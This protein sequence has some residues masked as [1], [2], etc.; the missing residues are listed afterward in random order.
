M[1]Y[2]FLRML[3]FE[4]VDVIY[5]VAHILGLHNLNVERMLF[6]IKCKISLLTWGGYRDGNKDIK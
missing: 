4:N 6:I 2:T 5:P 1:L 3:H